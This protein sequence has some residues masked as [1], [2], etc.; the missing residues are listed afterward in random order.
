MIRFVRLSN[1][2]NAFQDA[3]VPLN[4]TFEKFQSG[5]ICGTR[6]N[7]HC[8][9]RTVKFD[10]D[11]PLFYPRFERL[12]SCAA[13]KKTS[14]TSLDSGLVHRIE[15]VRRDLKRSDRTP[16]SS[17]WPCACASFDP[18]QS[19][20]LSRINC[21]YE[22]ILR[23]SNRRARNARHESGPKTQQHTGNQQAKGGKT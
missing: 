5:L 10:H 12:H 21:C 4:R 6:V 8:F 1:S 19:L 7:F 15:R 22:P 14:T 16:P 9:R 3:H 11:G 2:R 17:L 18:T 20:R 13:G 23:A